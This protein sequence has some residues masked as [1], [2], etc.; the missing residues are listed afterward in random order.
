MG[1]LHMAEKIAPAFFSQSFLLC[2]S[3]QSMSRQKVCLM[4]SIRGASNRDLVT[5]SSMNCEGVVY[6]NSS[7]IAKSEN[8]QT[9]SQELNDRPN[10]PDRCTRGYGGIRS[11]DSRRLGHQAVDCIY[12]GLTLPG[13][14]SCPGFV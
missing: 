5:Y 9:Y 7:K 4:L 14:Q 6:V 3:E 10:L 12:I 1:I 2:P 8:I 11:G 13:K